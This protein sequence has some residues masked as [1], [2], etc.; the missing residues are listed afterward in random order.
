VGAAQFAAYAEQLHPVAAERCH[1]KNF[2]I[3]VFRHFAVGI[4]FL[5]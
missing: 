1:G 3:V 4:I 5:S 2:V